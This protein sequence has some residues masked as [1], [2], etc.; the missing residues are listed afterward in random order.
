[1]DKF[2][3][4][5]GKL[6]VGVLIVGALVG[7]GYFLGTGK[8]TPPTY[9]P[10]AA[11]TTAPPAETPTPA[12][13]I[14]GQTVAGGG[15]SGTSFVSY[16]ITVPQPWTVKKEENAGI[17]QKVTISRGQYAIAIYQA[18]T[19]GSV[20]VY[21]GDPAAD[22]SSQFGPYVT[23]RDASGNEFRRAPPAG[24]SGGFT[25]CQKG[26]SLFG[27]PTIYGHVTYAVPAESDPA[28]IKEMDAIFAT[29]RKS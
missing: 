9:S 23:I 11:V 7:G 8:F 21:P 16:T 19:G 27:L 12:P 3:S 18:P 26:P 25:L 2:F 6:V 24:N 22:M 17:T 14:A 5:F 28:T 13:T 10:P 29:I 4:F 20:C 1:M 15:L